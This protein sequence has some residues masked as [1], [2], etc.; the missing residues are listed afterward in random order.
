MNYKFKTKQNKTVLKLKDK[1]IILCAC[2]FHI[3]YILQEIQQHTTTIISCNPGCHIFVTIEVLCQTLV[4]IA[5]RFEDLT[6]FFMSN[7]HRQRHSKHLKHPLRL[8]FGISKW[9]PRSIFTSSQHVPNVDTK[10][11]RI[12]L[13][14]LLRMQSVSLKFGCAD[15]VEDVGIR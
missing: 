2:F 13:G 3:Q 15:Y 12:C 10:F 1:S 11:T 9:C 5:L 7:G 6:C 8:L 4:M 14:V